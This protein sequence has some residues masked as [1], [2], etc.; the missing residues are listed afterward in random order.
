MLAEK[1]PPQ[2][3]DAEEAVLGSLL[4]DGEAIF[5]IAT[6]LRPED[7]Y[8]EKNRWVYEACFSLYERNEAID[9]VT[10]A[11]ELG[12]RERLGAVGGAAYL[13]HLVSKVPTSVYIEHYAQIVHCMSAMRRLISAGEQIKA[14]GYEAGPDVDAALSRAEDIL[15][16]LRHGQRPRDFVH[17]REVLDRYF[18]ES[19]IRPFAGEVVYTG[20][21]ALDDILGGLHRSDMIVL[22]ARPSLGK[23]SLAL[24]IARNTA[25]QQ[26]AHVAIFSLEMAREQLV[27]RLLASE[28]GVDSKRLRLGQQTE[29]EERKIMDATG[30]LSEAPIFVDDSPI[31]R[32]VE[33][34]SKARR[35][36]FEQGID[37]IIVDYMQ[38]MRGDGREGRVQEMTEVSRSLKELA[39]EL[40]VPVLA[41]SQ[42]SRASEWR[43]SHR[44][45]LSDLRESGSIEQDADVVVFIYRDDLHYTK[46][47]WLK[48]HPEKEDN[49]YPKGIAEV[50][51]AK[52]R[53]GPIGTVNLRFRERTVKFEDLGSEVRA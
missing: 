50:I 47:E 20:F 44:P 45:Q 6:F 32:V 48:L 21:P 2:D 24:G 10:V 18:E 40:D 38:L 7:F 29:A 35:L 31:L 30:V 5:K 12:R 26:G 33:L 11:H 27:Q 51:I 36:H 34:R 23:T 4:I 8:R 22:A 43:A 25:V 52:H 16:R 46:D 39:R 15:F 28:S 9:Q 13:S 53:N 42:L 41:V 3:I 19:E 17:I 49:E 1:L 37:L 14:I